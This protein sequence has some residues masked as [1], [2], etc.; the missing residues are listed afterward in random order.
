MKNYFTVTSTK[1]ITKPPKWAILQRRL[2]DLINETPELIIKK[3]VE[4]NGYMM[5]PNDSDF[6]SVDALDDMYESFFNWPLF[7]IIGGHEKF[8][9]LSHKQFNAITEQFSKLD[10]GYGHTMVVNGYEQG[11]DWMHQG[12][13]YLFFYLLNLADPRNQDNIEQSVKFAGFLLNE[14]IDGEDN[15]DFKYNV[16]RSCYVGSMGAGKRF[17]NKKPWA[18]VDWKKWYG[19][20]YYDIPGISNIDDIKNESLA[21]KMAEV[22]YDRLKDSDTATNLAATSMILNAYMHTGDHKY[23]EWI[24]NYI[25]A[26]K[27][28]MEKNSGIMPDNRGPDGNFGSCMNGKWYG[29]H[30]GWTWPHGFA[31][32]GDPLTIAC[33]NETLLTK[34]PDNMDMIRR[35]MDIMFSNAIFYDSTIYVPQK[36][37]EPGAVKEYYVHNGRFLIEPNEKPDNPTYSRLLEKDGWFEFQ[38]LSPVCPTHLWFATR[39][40]KDLEFL[41]NIRNHEKK[42]YENFNPDYS[43]Y[44]GGNDAMWINYLI[45]GLGDYP[46]R[47]MEHAI[48]QVYERLAFIHNDNEPR[49]EY[50]DAY[51]Q[52]RNPVTAE[53]LVQLTMGGPMPLY[54]GGLLNVSVIYYDIDNKRPGLPNDVAALVSEIKADGIDITLINLSPVTQKQL[55][56][57]AGAFG[58]HNF[59]SADVEDNIFKIN[60]NMFKVIL[61]PA[62]IIKMRLIT[63]R[64]KNTPHY[65]YPF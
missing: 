13:G 64:Y 32:M 41:K 38:P 37:A 20:P 62:S 16:M 61:N 21:I 48:N 12:E 54:N 53:A 39:D 55:L 50:S 24:L 11:Y 47:A 30:Y 9:N 7:Y 45:G 40:K 31:T 6:A 33:E 35:Q 51:L 29:G 22:M 5:W 23:A 63:D 8:L 43:K 27:C 18:W 52:F 34:N 44:Q 14:N 26:W 60:D 15:Y 49:E 25:G 4:P 28:E 59:I 57:Q 42:D 58:E 36:Y 10:T 19:L 46:E 2:I 56:I 65:Q 17:F 1:N 3:Y